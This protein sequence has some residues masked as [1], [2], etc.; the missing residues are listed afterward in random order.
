MNPSYDAA[1]E[2]AIEMIRNGEVTPSVTPV[3]LSDGKK[4]MISFHAYLPVEEIVD[5]ASPKHELLKVLD[6]Q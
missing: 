1:I 6:I 4:L 5:A 3:E 2:L